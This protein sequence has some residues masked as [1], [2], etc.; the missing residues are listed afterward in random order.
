MIKQKKGLMGTPGRK[1]NNAPLI[2]I[3]FCMLAKHINGAMRSGQFLGQKSLGP[4]KKTLE[5]LAKI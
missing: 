2:L 1:K 5:I 3:V 4:I